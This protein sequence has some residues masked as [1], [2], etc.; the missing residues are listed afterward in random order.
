MKL[1]DKKWGTFKISDLFRIE[2]CKCGNASLLQE[3]NDVFYR[4]AKKSENGVMRKVKRDDALL[5]KGNCIVFICDGD[6][7]CGYTNYVADDFIGSTTTSVGYNENINNLTGPFVVSILDMH[8]YKYSHS[9]K[10]RTSLPNEI[11]MLPVDDNGNPDWKWMENYMKSLEKDTDNQ[12]NDIMTITDGDK[13]T[14][15][16]FTNKV[17][18]DDFRNWLKDN[19]NMDTDKQ[20]LLEDVDWQQF[21]IVDLFEIVLSTG[22]IKLNQMEYGDVRLISSG[23]EN[24]GLVGFIDSNG[25]GEAKMFDANCLTVDMFGNAFYQPKAFYSV[26]HGRVNILLPKFPL[27]SNIGIFIATLIMK[28]Q[29]KYNYGRAVYSNI[30]A[31]MPIKLPVN[32]DGSP[33]WEWIE[34]Y[35]TSLPYSDKKS[36]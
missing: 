21:K 19:A 26:S 6:G 33:N 1:T 8:K 35:M 20:M 14:I 2:P 10:Y 30:V 32:A 36:S 22:D 29:Y 16:I 11:I 7:S 27:S 12:I 5:S 18:I 3:G 13:D 17:E 4:G 28:E 23:K 31:D 24:N 15:K 25:D 9:H 34:Q